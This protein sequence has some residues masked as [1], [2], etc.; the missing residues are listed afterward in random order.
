MNIRDIARIAGVSASTV[1]KVMNGKDH[2]ISD[3]TRR[4]VL[5]VIDQEHYI[6]YFKFLEKEGMKSRLIGMIVRKDSQLKQEIQLVAEETAREKGYGVV[7]G[8]TDG[9][10]TSK[11]I[12]KEMKAKKISG[13]LIEDSHL[14]VDGS[15]ED[16][17]VYLSDTRS[18]DEKQNTT[19][20]YRLSEATKLAVEQ[21]Y[22]KGHQKIGCIAAEMSILNGYKTAM[23]NHNLQYN[24]VWIYTSDSIRD[25]EKIGISQVIMERITAIV[26]G[27]PEIARCVERTLTRN[28]MM[29]PDEISLI[30]IGDEQALEYV[31]NG[32]TAIQFPVARMVSDAVK[33]LIDMIMKDKRI[34]VIRKFDPQIVMRNSVAKPSVDRQGEKIV[35]VGSMNMDVTIKVN[36]I[37]NTGET[38]M[39]DRVYIFPGGKGG[40]Q[41]VGVGKLDG[42]V[43]IIGCLGNDIEGRQI[44]TNLTENHVH[45]DGIRFDTV[46]PTGKAY[47]HVDQSGESAITVYAGANSGL[48]IKQLDKYEYLFEK[49]KFCLVS[50]EIPEVIVKHTIRLCRENGTQ[51]ILKPTVAGIMK[52]EIYQD[53]AYLVPNEKELHVLIPGEKTIEEKAFILKDKGV[54]NVIVTLGARGCYLK[55][56][57]YSLYFDGTGFEAVDTTGGADSFISALA[58]YL[59]EGRNLLE[60]IEF[61]I[62]A[63]GIS[64][65]RQGVQQALPDRKAVDIYED[66]IHSKK[67]LIKS[68]F[69]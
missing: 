69:P 41:A 39:A 60:A 50:T 32:I 38:Q 29:V 23:Q 56:D 30:S 42:Q 63:S 53:I 35:V 66:E 59:S 28:N 58:V 33:C 2:D 25:I 18:F 65:T 3:E 57:N 4:K 27:T 14:V 6:P 67:M 8:Y 5:N 40:N 34:E 43:F 24:P 15:M 44:Y 46:L 61:A 49:A 19:F 31:G 37:P 47:I 7:V 36:Q 12:V 22:Q 55:N 48:S 68:V 21:L 45:V 54:K 10:E 51:V 16:A 26:C 1:S 17:V 9:L 62:Y 52:E 11:Q 64:V 20:Y 13:F